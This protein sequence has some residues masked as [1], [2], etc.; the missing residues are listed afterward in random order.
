MFVYVRAKEIVICPGYASAVP[1]VP[2]D[3]AKLKLGESTVKGESCNI[4]I[5][6][7]EYKRTTYMSESWVAPSL[8]LI[9]T[10]SKH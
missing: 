9:S 3:A 5:E 2:S 4:Y 10:H 6:Q 1:F 7:R 8:K